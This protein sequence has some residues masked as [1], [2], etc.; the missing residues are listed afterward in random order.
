MLVV[1]VVAAEM[2]L[3]EKL[4]NKQLNL[5]K[6]L[7]K[8]SISQKKICPLASGFFHIL[9]L[10]PVDLEVPQ[11]YFLAILSIAKSMGELNLGDRMTDGRILAIS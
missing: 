9:S 3:V 1:V 6:K 7:V 5:L 10:T 11:L 4:V 2:L 8:N